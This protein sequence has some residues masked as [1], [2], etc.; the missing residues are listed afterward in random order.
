MG[1]KFKRI[2]Y[3]LIGAVIFT[4]LNVLNVLLPTANI[5]N[6]AIFQDAGVPDERIVIIGMDREAL[7]EFGAWPWD[8]EIMAQAISYLNADPDNKPAVI[9]IDVVFD[10]VD[11]ELS[12]KKLIEAV[13]K[14]DNV[15][16]SS[17]AIYGSSVIEQGN[18]DFYLDSS[19]VLDLVEPYDEL[20]SVSMQGHV[21]AMRDTDGILRHAIWEIETLDGEII[22]SFNKII[23]EKYCEVMDLPMPDT[24]NIDE[25]SRWYVLQQS[26][27][28]AYSDGI[29]FADLVN[30]SVSPQFFADKIV[31]IGPY[32]TSFKDEYL[33]A[34]DHAENMAGVEYQANAIGA[35]LEGDNIFEARTLSVI[36]LF[37]ISFLAFLMLP[38]IGLIPAAVMSAIAII[39][40]FFS[41]MIAF[42]NGVL[43]TTLYVPIAIL[44]AYIFTIILNYF[45]ESSQRKY[46]ASTFKRY[47]APEIVNELL[48]GDPDTLKLGGDTVDV[49]VIFVDV[50]GFTAISTKLSPATVVEMLNGILTLTTDCILNNKGTLD[51][52]I[53]DCTMAFWGAPLEQEDCAYKAVKTAI[54]I[55]AGMAK[56]SVEL[57]EKFG[58]EVSCGIGV[59]YGSVV[60]G[61]IGA[62]SRMNYTIIGDVVNTASRL[63]N[64][65]APDEIL[66][67]ATVA[68]ILAGRVEFSNLG[69][70]IKLKGK[71]EDFEIYRVEEIL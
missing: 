42:D 26:L 36:L 33:T 10:S 12:D 56:L 8:R 62:S 46:I 65:A 64:I 43:I 17:Y 16:L 51:K 13:A 31:L 25:K 50:R 6:D 67:S 59:D 1:N 9:G 40:W 34:I 55:K 61:N 5:V 4:A 21:N 41:C 45:T 22:P 49:G 7:E 32:D 48:K 14:E 58:Y 53:G 29:S 27:P 39:A 68:E 52:Y 18:G 24:P 63:E 15:V 19:S 30:Q 20:K 28:G 54:D 2:I 66:V 23:T 47:V 57:K 38:L 3:A 69:N 60:V 37:I 71:N 44:G 70:E 35:L 11:N